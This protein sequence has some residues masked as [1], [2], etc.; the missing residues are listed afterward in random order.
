MDKE[1]L[2]RTMREYKK[3]SGVKYAITNPD[4]LGD[5]QSCVNYALSQKYGEDSKGV[6]VKHW[7]SGM[8]KGEPIAKLDRLFIGHDITEEQGNILYEVFSKHFVVSPKEYD[9]SK[10]YQIFS[11]D[12]ELFE[13]SYTDNE[14]GRTYSDIYVGEGKALARVNGLSRYPECVDITIRKMV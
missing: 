8:N 1:L 14:N 13:V 2:K 11:K 6:W 10:C 5:C 4:N 3:A 7:N 9:E 12:A